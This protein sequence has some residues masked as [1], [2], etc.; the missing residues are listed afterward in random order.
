[1]Y[2][3]KFIYKNDYTEDS[4]ITDYAT[5]KKWFDDESIRFGVIKLQMIDVLANDLVCYTLELN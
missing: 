5:A 4:P 2:K 1:M 3:V